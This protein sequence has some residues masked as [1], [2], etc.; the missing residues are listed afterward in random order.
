MCGAPVP[1]PLIGSSAYRNSVACAKLCVCLLHLRGDHDLGGTT[2]RYCTNHHTLHPSTAF[3]QPKSAT[4]KVAQQLALERKLKQQAQSNT[5]SEHG[6]VDW[7]A[8]ADASASP[9][10]GVKTLALNTLSP[11][12]EGLDLDALFGTEDDFLLCSCG[13]FDGVFGC[14]HLETPLSSRGVSVLPPA[15]GEG[16]LA[17]C[18]DPG[19]AAAL[20][21][22]LSAK[23]FEAARG[24]SGRK[25]RASA[26]TDS[27][28]A[29][30]Y[31][32]N[33]P[34]KLGQFVLN[35]LMRKST[36][37]ISS[38]R[39]K[40]MRLS[41]KLR[42]GGRT[43]E[44]YSELVVVWSAILRDCDRRL[45]IQGRMLKLPFLPAP[46]K[47]VL[48]ET[49]SAL[50]AYQE[51]LTSLAHF[52]EMARGECSEEMLR[53]HLSMA[54]SFLNDQFSMILLAI[55]ER[56]EWHSRLSETQPTDSVVFSRFMNNIRD[57]ILKSARQLFRFESL[58]N[59]SDGAVV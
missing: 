52:C 25:V 34:S 41:W 21:E 13:D 37:F 43:D 39:L 4:C 35:V 20:M 56:R 3:A 46:T 53:M 33:A 5:A 57:Q 7:G 28:A 51:I 10:E 8:S 11:S 30:F 9:G 6:E 12:E 50:K 16:A 38:V 24:V 2:V 48:E 27:I 17:A 42:D 14:A 40:V 19:A 29:E 45:K 31:M 32:T 15:Q 18:Y 49:M 36:E 55:E 47:V 26:T 23:G 59:A 1:T 58:E 44:V 22:R 54:L